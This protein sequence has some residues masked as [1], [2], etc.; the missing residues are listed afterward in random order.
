[1][2]R[3]IVGDPTAF[4]MTKI[5]LSITHVYITRIQNSGKIGLFSSSRLGNQSSVLV[6]HDCEKGMWNVH[7][8]T[9]SRAVHRN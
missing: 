3:V 6:E 2:K 9:F 7:I 8:N 4:Y 5:G 1:M